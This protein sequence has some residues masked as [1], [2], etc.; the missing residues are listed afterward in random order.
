MWLER[1]QGSGLWLDTWLSHQ[2]RDEYWRPASVSEDYSAIQCP[3]MAVG[4]W[5]DG[6]T[7]AIFRL[8]EHVEVPCHGLIGP[9]G[10][11]YP[12]LG[13][14]GPAIGFLQELVRW[15]DHWLKGEDTGIDED[16]A[17]RA[18]MQDSVPPR[19]AYEER[20]GRWVARSI[21]PRRASPSG[22][23]A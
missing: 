7:N 21:G 15:W 16:P 19:A 13:V 8:L 4:G 1:L 6:Y 12:H 17:L 11:K 22:S 3:V 23:S 10:H 18:W 14:P 9:W 20:P 5:A 2:R